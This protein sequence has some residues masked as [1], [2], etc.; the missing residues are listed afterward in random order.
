M[1]RAAADHTD[2]PRLLDLLTA[3]IAEEAPLLGVQIGV[4]VIPLLK[5]SDHDA[6]KWIFDRLTSVQDGNGPEDTSQLLTIAR[7]HVANLV[8][9]EGDTQRAYELYTAALA[10]CDPASPEYGNLLNNRGITLIELDQPEAAIAD[11]TA[12]IDASAASDEARACALNNRADE[13]VK[14][15]DLVGAIADRSGVL[16]LADT[17]Y[18]RRYIALIRRATALRRTGDEAGA[19]DD[20]ET[21]LATDDIAVEQKMAARL[22]RANWL[23]EAGE[24]TQAQSDLEKII[25]SR[26]NFDEVAEKARQLLNP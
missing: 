10:E 17:T 18:N 4:A 9:R 6:V 19:N 23:M 1:E 21:I 15:N 12:V 7:F 16:Q 11:F 24:I 3:R 5:R 2:H 13:L 22:E 20:I 25:A 26:R 8:L 14:K